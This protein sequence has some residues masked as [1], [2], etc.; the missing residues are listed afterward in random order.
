MTVLPARAAMS[1]DVED[2]F[3]VENLSGAIARDTWD[4][5]ELRVER[6][7][8]RMLDLMREHG[9]HGAWFVL[10]WVAER[11]PALVRQIAAEGHEIASH[12]FGHER[13]LSP[14]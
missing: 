8:D 12:G 10:G 5:R 3:Q 14:A 9:V 13:R 6:N 2:W 7:V 11:V 1:V 4:E